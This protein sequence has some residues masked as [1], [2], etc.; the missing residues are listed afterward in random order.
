MIKHLLV[1][2]DGSAQSRNAA[3]FGISLAAQTG[4]EVTLLCVLEL[5]AVIP[6]GPVSSY[7]MVSPAITEAEVAHA[8]AM[9]EEVAA[10]NSAVKVTP[11]VETGHVSD[12]ICDVAAH[13]NVDVIVMGARGLGA[14]KRL[15]L[16]SISDQ[17]AHHAHVPV[18]IWR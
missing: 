17:V 4:A 12:V 11:R 3:R 14:A 5:P 7:L 8:A 13:L 16:G 10:E 9:L 6:L 2:I 18:L 15:V 1:A